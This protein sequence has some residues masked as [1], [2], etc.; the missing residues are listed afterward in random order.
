MKKKIFSNDIVNSGRQ[1]ELDI[2]KAV[3]LFFLAFIHCII[4]CTPESQ[5]AHGIPYLFDTIIGG[6][7][8]APMYMFAM[9]MGMTYT[10]QHSPGDFFRRGI[11]IEIVGYALNVCRFLLPS[12][13]GYWIT[14]DYN[15]Y[16]T[17]LPYRFFGN[18]ILQ[19]AGLAMILMALFTKLRLSNWAMLLI[20]LGMSVAGT[21]LKGMNVGNPLGNIF[22]G[23]L[24]GTEDAIGQVLSDFPLL[25]WMIIPVS[26]YVFGKN[27]LHVKNKT[28]FYAILSPIGFL[29]TL[30]YFPIA[31]RNGLGM[32]GEGQN[33]YY[34]M[35][36]LDSII[37]LALT[38]GLLGVYFVL[39]RYIPEK[40][41]AGIRDMSRNINVIYCVHWVILA[42]CIYVILYIARGTQ[43]LPVPLT[44]ALG[45]SIS[46]ASIFIAHF[47]SNGW[48]NKIFRGRK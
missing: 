10:I 42:I 37:C 30:V 39:A 5:L 38:V 24:I 8:S 47:W 4:A 15:Q 12:L 32:F 6:P 48:K 17:P 22:L 35:S 28:Y 40:V 29:I 2:A 1:K 19:F 34:H 16:I 21:L 20:C 11:K 43:E 31:I 14:R 44:L 3:M 27:L 18:D 13:V 25:N 9:G 36:T 26:G 33:C 46:V 41:M 23:Y 7:F 45:L